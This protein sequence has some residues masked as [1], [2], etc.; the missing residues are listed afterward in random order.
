MYLAVQCNGDDHCNA[1]SQELGP[2]YAVQPEQMVHEQQQRNIDQTLTAE[3]EQQ[4]FGSLADGL[5]GIAE[6]NR[7]LQI[8]TGVARQQIRRNVV[9]SA[10]V[11]ASL[12]NSRTI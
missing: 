4:G 8:I 5:E 6:Q 11:S 7:K 3:G 10:S 2:Y 12:M 9:P 1:V